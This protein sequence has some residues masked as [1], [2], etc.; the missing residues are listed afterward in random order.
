MKTPNLLEAFSIAL[1]LIL[2]FAGTAQAGE[3]R[4]T[5]PTQGLGESRLS[6]DVIYVDNE[7]LT[8]DSQDLKVSWT[9]AIAKSPVSVQVSSMV[10]LESVRAA[11]QLS[12]SF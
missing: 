8:G 2:I 12:W 4:L 1:T 3:H 5:L 9:E 10:N 6:T 7:D 11:A